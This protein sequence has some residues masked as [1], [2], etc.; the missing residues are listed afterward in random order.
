MANN[1]QYGANHQANPGVVCGVQSC[2]FH[3]QHNHC[4]LN[5]IHIDPLSQ[6]STG[7]AAD[8]TLCGS[9]KNQA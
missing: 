6:G 4:S 5:M 9:Y 7:S 8:E 1:N 2:K 3:D